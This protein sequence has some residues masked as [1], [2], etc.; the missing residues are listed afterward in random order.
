MYTI[1]FCRISILLLKQPTYFRRPIFV[2]S[3][4]KYTPHRQTDPA[5]VD[6]SAHDNTE[7]AHQQ[8]ASTASRAAAASFF[9]HTK[10]RLFCLL[11]NFF[12]CKTS[13]QRFKKMPTNP[14]DWRGEEAN[15]QSNGCEALPTSIARPHTH[16]LVDRANQDQENPELTVL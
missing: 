12:C 16:C 13:R 2:L 14:Q 15:Q 9:I 8:S 1:V 11:C 3:S 4:P 6:A 7:P 5:A 10:V